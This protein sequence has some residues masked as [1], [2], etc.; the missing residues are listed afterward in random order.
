MRAHW[1]LALLGGMTLIGPFEQPTLSAVNDSVF[2]LEVLNQSGVREGT[3]VA[4]YRESAGEET[5]L[6]LVTSARLFERDTHRRARLY[7]HGGAPVDIEPRAIS[8]PYMNARDIAVLKVTVVARQPTST[9]PVS[10]DLVRAGTPFAIAGVKSDG[11]EAVAAQ[12]VRFSA[13]RTV[14]GSATTASLAGCQGAPAIADGRVFGIV[15]ECGSDR[16]PEI[17]PLSVSRSFLL[18]TIPGLVDGSEP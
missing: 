15:S 8:T 16:V 6:V 5:L 3:G 11:S 4:V 7:L 18:R 14:L 2:R 17:T 12:Q 1:V 13:T 9:L 10:F